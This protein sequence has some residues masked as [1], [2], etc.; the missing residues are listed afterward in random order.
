MATD[1]NHAEF[2]QV[3]RIFET[4]VIS[5]RDFSAISRVYTA[6]AKLLPPGAEMLTGMDHIRNFWEQAVSSLNVQSLNL[7]T[8]DLQISGDIAVEVGRAEMHMNQPTSPTTV[9][10]VVIW[11]RD[12]EGWKWDVDIWNADAE[13]HQQHSASA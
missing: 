7:S 10:Y 2:Q 5:K 13:A 6:Q 11:K 4:D 3:N 8:L 9:K 12:N 1:Q